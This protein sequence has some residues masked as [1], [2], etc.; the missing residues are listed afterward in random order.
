M[1]IKALLL[2]IAAA[3]AL[4]SSSDDDISSSRTA[5]LTITKTSLVFAAEG[6]T[7]TFGIKTDAAWTAEA[8]TWCA[9]SQTYGE[10]TSA[11]NIKVTAE[12]NNDVNALSGS[13]TITSGTETAAISVSQAANGGI[14][15]S[16]TEFTLD[17]ESCTIEISAIATG[18]ITVE[19]Y[20]AWITLETLSDN[21]YTFAIAANNVG[22]RTGYIVFTYG[23]V[24]AQI[25][26]TQASGMTAASTLSV[27]AKELASK[28][29]A[30]INIGNTLEATSGETS[31]G[32]PKVTERY[33]SGLK[34][35][36][37]NAVRIPCAWTNYIVNSE[38]YEIDSQWLDRVDE[39]VSYVIGNEMYAIVNIHWDGGWL[40]D[41]ISGGYSDAINAKQQ[42]LWTQIA[43]RLADYDEHLIFAG[44]N[45]P[46]MNE[47]AYTTDNVKTIM[48]Y[49][50]T[51]VDA[52][53]ATGGANASRCLIV[54]GTGTNIDYATNGDF[55]I[56]TD[57]IDDRILV[58][59]HYYDPY[60][61][62][63]MEED[64]SWG[65]ML[66]YWGSNTVSDETE[67]NCGTYGN[68][69]YIETQMGKLKTAFVDKGIPCII[70]EYCANK[71]TVTNQDAHNKSRQEW[72][73]AVTRIAK[74]NGC[75]PFYWETGVD[76]NRTTGE[77]KED[78]AIQGIMEGAAA[79]T[80]PW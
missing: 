80:Y 29:N 32:N 73:A 57:I 35:L 40:E 53:R 25:S 72:N 42:A 68:E 45:E 66:Y 60:Q 8:P 39:V 63:L 74:N 16:Q 43:T 51:F 37:F 77:A 19:S 58:E 65:K 2:G 15:V 5:N 76:I 27:T 34:T 41:N 67:R 31:W 49:E 64:A 78:Y 18:E 50:Q 70:G 54:Q 71:R 17:A 75:V 14:V 24:T 30:G 62:C 59:V 55:T 79:G 13:I 56:P 12:E 1:K 28:I 23:D 47:S 26:V 6:G 22:Q 48:R 3:I 52:V 61:F 10:A 44:C 33:I 36:G 4:A 46:G 7:Q 9:L 38:T 11:L 21:T 69:A 20:A